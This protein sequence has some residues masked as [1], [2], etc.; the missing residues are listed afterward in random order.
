[1]DP[2]SLDLVEITRLAEQMISGELERLISLTV[3]TRKADYAVVT[4]VQIHHWAAREHAEAPDLEFVWPV[5]VRTVVKGATR[6]INLQSVPSL[7]PRQIRILGA[8]DHASGISHATALAD[9]AHIQVTVSKA[10]S[11]NREGPR[12]IASRQP[13]AA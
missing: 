4:G 13:A 1:M 6:V 7:S 5:T 8:H 12:C 11:V 3:D 2:S 10:I 9:P